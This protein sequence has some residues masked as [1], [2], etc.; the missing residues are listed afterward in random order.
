MDERSKEPT[1]EINILIEGH[2]E[3]SISMIKSL[4]RNEW[5]FRGWVPT[6]GR[7]GLVDI[8]RN[9]KRGH[10]DVIISGTGTGCLVGD[11]SPEILCKHLKSIAL[12]A[13]GS[14]CDVTVRYRMLNPT[15][16]TYV[17]A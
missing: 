2:K 4:L 3:E 8:G 7:D 1:V 9:S 6:A 15:P 13:N 14:D 10:E 17:E 5:P 11:T 12:S 16:W